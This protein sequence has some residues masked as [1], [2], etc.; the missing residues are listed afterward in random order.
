VKSS[1]AQKNIKF[2]QQGTSEER[3]LKKEEKVVS[4]EKMRR[5]ITER[6]RESSRTENRDEQRE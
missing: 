3:C 2:E 1:R 6:E 4:R 5:R